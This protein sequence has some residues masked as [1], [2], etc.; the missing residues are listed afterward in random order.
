M[1]EIKM[2]MY[3][4]ISKYFLLKYVLNPVLAFSL[5]YFFRPFLSVILIIKSLKL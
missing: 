1:Q 5:Y 4:A 2:R 3:D